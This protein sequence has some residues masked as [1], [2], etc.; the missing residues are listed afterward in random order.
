MLRSRDKLALGDSIDLGA[1]ESIGKERELIG[2]DVETILIS[3]NERLVAKARAI[4]MAWRAVVAVVRC[5]NGEEGP[6]AIRIASLGDGNQCMGTHAWRGVYLKDGQ[7]PAICAGIKVALRVAQEWAASAGGAINRKGQAEESIERRWAAHH[8]VVGCAIHRNDIIDRLDHKIAAYAETLVRWLQAERV[9]ATGGAGIKM[10]EAI[11][12]GGARIGVRHPIAHWI[13][14]GRWRRDRH[15][16]SVRNRLLIGLL[17]GTDLRPTVGV[18][19][20]GGSADG[21]AASSSQM[22]EVLHGW[23]RVRGSIKEEGASEHSNEGK[24]TQTDQQ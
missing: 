6:H 19:T 18:I 7:E 5:I 20:A 10:I 22:P 3:A 11:E 23:R 9:A 2:G 15:R 24:A 8:R 14:R 4:R 17:L 16:W 21:R 13:G 12:A 1:V